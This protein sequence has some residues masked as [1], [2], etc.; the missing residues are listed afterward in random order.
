M[1][2]LTAHLDDVDETYFQHM[3]HALGFSVT[4]LL[5]A[6]ACAVHALAPFL[7]VKTGSR[8]IQV[9]HDRMAVNRRNLSPRRS[10]RVA[11]AG[12]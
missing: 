5:T 11:T 10:E 9:L 12:R 4:M 7:F 3:G 2:F 1:K 8:C 6:L